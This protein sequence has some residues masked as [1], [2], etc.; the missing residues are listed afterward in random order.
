MGAIVIVVLITITVV[1]SCAGVVQ[2]RID[3][4]YCCLWFGKSGSAIPLVMFI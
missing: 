4:V 3:I 2:F 1:A